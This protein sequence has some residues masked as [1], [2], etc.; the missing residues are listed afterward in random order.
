MSPYPFT[1]GFFPISSCS[2]KNGAWQS[3]LSHYR[4]KLSLHCCVLTKQCIWYN[5]LERMAIELS[6]LPQSTKSSWPEHFSIAWYKAQG[7]AKCFWGGCQ[8]K[9][10]ATKAEPESLGAPTSQ[11]SFFPLLLLFNSIAL[12]WF[13]AL[14]LLSC[15][16]KFLCAISAKSYTQF[17]CHKLLSGLS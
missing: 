9:D 8:Q 15:R 6:L 12:F 17:T 10:R 5:T 11:K 1:N 13:I 3:L 2:S 7:P 16:E 14:K 4:S